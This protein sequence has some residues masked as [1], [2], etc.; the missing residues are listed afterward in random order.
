VTRADRFRLVLAFTAI[1]IIWGSTYLAIKVGLRSFDPFF[2]AG[3]RYTF[4]C[5][6]GF[7]IARAR[8]VTFGGPL[9]RWLPAFGV[10]ALLVA[11]CNGIVFWSET[12]LDSGFTALLIT[13]SPVWT[14]LLSPAS[15]EPAPGMLGWL[16][17]ALGFA[18]TTVLLAPWQANAVTLWPAVAVQVSVVVW[19]GCSLW[20]RRI[21][22]R[23]HPMALSVAQ[24]AAGAGILLAVAGVRGKALVGPVTLPSLAALSYLVVFGSVVAFA[25]Y[26][27]LLHHWEAARVSTSTYVNPV[28]AVALGALILGE[29]VTLRMIAGAVIILGGVALVLR[30][31]R[32]H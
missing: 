19:A 6:L 12:T 4:A 8:G 32:G 2:Y 7:A 5:L 18:G 26:F 1:C 17:I 24:M 13:T 27:Y 21:R 30:E 15:G 23:Y 20:V 22:D 9:R 14:A 25:S 11:F 10:G 29:P 31:R 16:G 28:V 3:L